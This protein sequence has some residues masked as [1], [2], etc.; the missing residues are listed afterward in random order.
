MS[1]LTSDSNPKTSVLDAAAELRENMNYIKKFELPLSVAQ[2]INSRL[3]LNDIYIDKPT[4]AS[5]IKLNSYV[6][7]CLESY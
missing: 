5:D 3:I 4:I 6:L 2:H 1:N 7:H